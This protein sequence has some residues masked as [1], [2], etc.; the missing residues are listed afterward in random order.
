MYRFRVLIVILA[1]LWFVASPGYAFEVNLTGSWIWGYD[2][3]DQY[4]REGFFGPYDQA[5][6]AANA[7]ATKFNSMN[8]FIGS[9]TINGEQYGLVTGSDASL[10]WSRMEI[11]P[12]IR[13][14]PA[15]RLRG[16]YQIGFGVSQF[17]LYP[18]N[19]D[20]GVYNPIASGTWTYWWLSAECPWGIIVA[21]KRPLDWGMGALFDRRNATTETFG[22]WANYGPM[23]IGLVFHPW[24]GQTWTNSMAGR[25]VISTTFAGGPQSNVVDA[26]PV[27]TIG[28]RLWD[29]DRK[30]NLHPEW[31]YVYASGPL[32]MGLLGEYVP[33]HNG[34]GGA[35]SNANSLIARTYDATYEDG[36]VFLKYNNGR[37]F[38]NNELAYF[39]EQ[40]TVQKAID[41]VA[42]FTDG[43]GSI[44]A[45]YNLEAWKYM[46]E[47]GAMAGPAKVSLFYSWVPGPDRR[48]GIWIKKQSWENVANGAQFATTQAFLPYSLLMAYQYGGGLN[49]INRN[50]EGYMTDAS[51]FGA[52]IDYAVAC[53]LDLFATLFTANRVSKGWG[54]G[55]LVPSSDG[56][57][58]GGKVLLLGQ[59]LGTDGVILT[60]P[61]NIL[62]APAPSIPD[63]SLGW[64]VTA[65]ADWKL[66]E[67]LIVHLRGAYWQP[68]GWFK[69]A[70]IDK[71]YANTFTTVAGVGTF[72]SPT[73]AD[74]PSGWAINPAREI[75]P[76]FGFQGIIEADF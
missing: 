14:N 27:D 7:S 13:I 11:L 3:F 70:C 60:A 2:Y 33:I 45:P 59:Q 44:F 5:S 25:D 30:R 68:G 71:L 54:W 57:N 67:G 16:L 9:R 58:G 26:T 32:E 62:A 73:A 65:G 61:Q 10:Q 49:A 23:R 22:V 74:G 29:N 53:N 6:A 76:I 48:H 35:T 8:S 18:N 1:G 50:G 56:T 39:K 63:D 17:G 28:Y 52:R 31:V 55:C 20:I 75:E 37:F 36:S 43:G 47:M 21:G 46:V 41:D 4:G 24:R 64:E 19:A 42:D 66:L 40:M 72:V 38:F 12:E 15:I 34:P 69:Y 51:S